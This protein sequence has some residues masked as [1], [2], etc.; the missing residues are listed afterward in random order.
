MDSLEIRLTQVLTDL[1][2]SPTARLVAAVSGGPDSMALLHLLAG[3]ADLKRRTTVAHVDHGLRAESI[4]EAAFV[5]AVADR[6][7]LPFE[8]TRLEIDAAAPGNLA[9]RLR[10]ARYAFLRQVAGESGL[11]LTAHHADDQ[12]VTVLMRLIEG[13]ALPGLQGI[14]PRSGNVLRPLLD[15][16][17]AELLAFLE[18][19]DYPYCSDPSNEDESKFRNRVRRRYLNLLESERPGAAARIAGVAKRLGEDDAY[20]QTLAT[21]LL[22]A[23]ESGGAW[24]EVHL[25]GV[26]PP[27][28]LRRVIARVLAAKWGLPPPHASQWDEI[29]KTLLLG[30]KANL[31]GRVSLQWRSGTLLFVT[32]D[33]GGLEYGLDLSSP[34]DYVLP[35][36]RLSV[37]DICNT[38]HVRPWFPGDH[39]AAQNEGNAPGGKVAR[40]LAKWAPA[41]RR[42]GWPVVSGDAFVYPLPAGVVLETP[43]GRF[44]FQP[45]VH[46][47]EKGLKEAPIEL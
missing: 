40:R 35:V 23:T 43:V 4:Q 38:V 22:D 15:V 36:G 6:L 13:A 29:E 7:C 24:V 12:A 25:D 39:E 2:A 19:N 37:L 8:T 1:G 46:T 33:R 28:L 26:P 30:A 11:I 41:H 45:L 20:L 47:G 10:T 16:P 34:G 18:G 14:R 31:P 27:P 42:K 3:Q 44:L 17:H 21:K 9:D 5:K 32:E